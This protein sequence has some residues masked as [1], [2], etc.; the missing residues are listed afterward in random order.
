MKV[1][2]FKTERPSPGHGGMVSI[3]NKSFIKGLTV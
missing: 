1:S 2:V 3:R